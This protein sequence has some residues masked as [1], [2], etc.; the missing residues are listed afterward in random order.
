MKGVWLCFTFLIFA[1]C[2]ITSLCHVCKHRNILVC[3]SSDL[4][5]NMI[6][7]VLLVAVST[8]SISNSW[9]SIFSRKASSKCFRTCSSD[10]PIILPRTFR[11]YANCSMS[12]LV[13][14]NVIFANTYV[15]PIRCLFPW[16]ESFHKFFFQYSHILY[17]VSDRLHPIPCNICWC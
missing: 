15:V 1:S 2:V 13:W 14:S 5:R 4:N 3:G 7:L 9:V 12:C 17:L 8:L 10:I 6:T 11:S 16:I